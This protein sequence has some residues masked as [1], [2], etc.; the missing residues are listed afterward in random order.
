MQR[1][2]SILHAEPGPLI[3]RAMVSATEQRPVK[4][5]PRLR[6]TLACL[7]EEDSEKQVAD[8][9]GLSHATPIRT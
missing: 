4:L 9:L 2:L 1:R 3:A 6:Q 5:S 7:L 8:R